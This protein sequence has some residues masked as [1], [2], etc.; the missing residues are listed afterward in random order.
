MAIYGIIFGLSV[1][2]VNMVAVIA[3]LGVVAL[4]IGFGAETLIEDVITDL[5][6]AY[7]A[8]LAQAEEAVKKALE[9]LPRQ[10]PKVFK[11]P[12]SYLGVESLGASSVDLRSSAVVEEPNIYTARRLLNRELKL[13]MDRAGISIPYPQVVVHKGED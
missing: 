12:P 7:E 3:S 5:S 8:D 11:K 13:A 9:E 2:G 1:L 10:Y 6:I 4:V